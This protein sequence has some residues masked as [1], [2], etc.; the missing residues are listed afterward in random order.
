MEDS[1]DITLVANKGICPDCKD[2]VW[3][4]HVHDFVT[5][6][7]GQLS[8]DG[9]NGSCGITRMRGRKINT[10]V[11]SESPFVVV[12]KHELRGGRGKNGDEPLTW[13]P[14][15]EMSDSW[16]NNTIT[17]LK[18]RGRAYGPHYKHLLMEVKYREENNITID[19]D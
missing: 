12:R 8:L 4:K 17:Y 15:C 3:S 1:D 13:T 5:C 9:G 11:Y 19:Y 10:S 7:C 6:S 14:I 18:E 2:E 16:L